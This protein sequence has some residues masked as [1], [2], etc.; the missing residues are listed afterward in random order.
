MSRHV[1]ILFTLQGKPHIVSDEDGDPQCWATM[2]EAS[3]WID[4]GAM[5]LGLRSAESIV[6]V[7]C[8]DGESELFM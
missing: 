2:Q 8:S 5:P 1:V 3:E 7:D 6:I 4:K